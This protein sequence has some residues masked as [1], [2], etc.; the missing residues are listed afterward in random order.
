METTKAKKFTQSL[1]FKGFIIAVLIL[2]LLIPQAMISDLIHERKYRSQET[3]DK[4]NEKWS[5]AQIVCGPILSIPYQLKTTVTEYI[6][7]KDNKNEKR[8]KVVY[9]S[10]TLNI[11]PEQLEIKAHLIPEEKY[12]GIYKTILYKSSLNITGKFKRF[13]NEDTTKY[14]F[15]WDKAYITLGLSDLKGVSDNVDFKF[16]NHTLEVEAGGNIFKTDVNDYYSSKYNENQLIMAVSELKMLHEN[17]SM[18]FQCNMSLNGSESI[19]FIPIGKITQV[20]VEGAWKTPSFIG[21]FSPDSKIGE[22]FSASWNIMHFNR[23]IPETWS[24][25]ISN[26]PFYDSY[27]GVNL[28]NAVDHYQQNERSSKYA[29]MFILLTFVVFF[30]VEALTKRKIHPLQYLLVGLALI[31]FYSLLLS[32]SEQLNFAMAYIIASIATIGLITAYTHSIFKNKSQTV[33]LSSLLCG[34]YVFLFVILQ[35]EDIALLIG[36]VGLFIILGVIMFVSRKI[37]FYKQDEDVS[38]NN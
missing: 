4:I 7:T 14:N 19:S 34:L 16:G 5:N 21:N 25:K 9:E 32:I 12:Y 38:T 20:N 8:E 28:I 27:F 33:I 26:R 18:S 31:L 1:T 13:S 10:H 35:L 29:I 17:E 22:S 11:T 24:D 2:L 30:F 36:S 23:N 6:E 15:E 37:N 3:I